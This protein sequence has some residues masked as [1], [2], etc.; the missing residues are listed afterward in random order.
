MTDLVLPT[1][2]SRS[3]NKAIESDVKKSFVKTNDLLR[4]SLSAGLSPFSVIQT[5]FVIICSRISAQENL[6]LGSALNGALFPIS[7][8]VDL[9]STFDQL[10]V[11][12][13]EK[14]NDASSKK[15]QTRVA[16]VNVLDAEESYS[17][18]ELILYVSQS[19]SAR[20]LLD[21]SMKLVYN[22][23][24]FNQQ[25][26]EDLLDQIEE[27]IHTVVVDPS[28]EIGKIPMIT[29]NSK[30]RLPDP[31]ADLGWDQF[32]GAITDV[33]TKNA[34]NLPN[35]TCVVESVEN[36]HRI[37]TYKQILEASNI[38]AHF[39]INHGIQRGDIV[40]LYSSRCV[41]LVVAVMGVLK[42]GAAFSVIGNFVNLIIDPAYPP[43][44]QNVYLSVAQPR[45]LVILRKAGVLHEDVRNYINQ[46]LSV[47]VEVPSLE[48]DSDGSLSGDLN[49]GLFQ[50]EC[51]A[52]DIDPGII[53]GPDSIGTLSF[54]SGS[55]GVPK[56]VRGRHFS[57]THFYPWMK[58]EF[59][60]T[61][62]E[63]FTMLSGI[64]HD[65]IQR[66]SML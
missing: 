54:T 64:A 58:E 5:A 20:A 46:E 21:I 32:E 12:I 28:I 57:L 59:G 13:Q 3:G 22:S 33:F 62:K 48:M 26:M 29:L 6:E 50:K 38:L 41:D 24:L 53:L 49:N 27:I 1:D 65:P 39:L 51:K 36:G 23:L 45:G 10:L 9:N 66:D 40:V 7:V 17:Q 37:F 11:Q 15:G 60:L 2:F 63:R 31:T 42:A 25:R 52:K 44:R 30:L 14:E 43:A 18:A 47:I 19:A 16:C 4:I 56:G 35:A 34:T 55:T 8:R 61:E